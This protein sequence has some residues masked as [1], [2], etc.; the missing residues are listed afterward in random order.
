MRILLYVLLF[1][2]CGIFLLGYGYWLGV[3]S[4]NILGD[5]KF[6]AAVVTLGGRFPGLGRAKPGKRDRKSTRLNSSH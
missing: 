4:Y 3:D 5:V 6:R 2:I 1:L